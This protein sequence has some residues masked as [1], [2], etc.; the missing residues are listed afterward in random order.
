MRFLFLN[1]SSVQTN[2]LLI[3]KE[4]LE[5]RKKWWPFCQPLNSSP[6]GTSKQGQNFTKSVNL[7]RRTSL[8][9]FNL[10]A[11]DRDTAWRNKLNM[12][13]L[14]LPTK[15]IKFVKF[16]WPIRE[17]SQGNITVV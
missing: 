9:G 5:K 6:Q 17:M 1:A 12:P 10:L 15:T 8:E 3:I 16:E 13:V 4:P 11:Q 2:A 7:F 14:E